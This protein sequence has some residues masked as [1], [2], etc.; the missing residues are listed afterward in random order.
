MLFVMCL[1]LDLYSVKV[2]A[3]T[4]VA[5]WVLSQESR[6]CPRVSFFTVYISAALDSR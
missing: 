5:A 3:E 4:W 1:T 2:R 6:N